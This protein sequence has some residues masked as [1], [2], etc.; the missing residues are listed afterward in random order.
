VLLRGVGE[1][2]EEGGSSC[3]EEAALEGGFDSGD[4]EGGVCSRRS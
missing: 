2:G 4:S 3:A 1:I